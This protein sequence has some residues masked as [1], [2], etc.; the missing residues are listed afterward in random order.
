M[1][2]TSPIDTYL[3]EFERYESHQLWYRDPSKWIRSW[4]V[5]KVVTLVYLTIL[6]ALNFWY[7]YNS[8]AWRDK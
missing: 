2:R 6:F 5:A 1:K 8:L 7:Y 3:K 4:M